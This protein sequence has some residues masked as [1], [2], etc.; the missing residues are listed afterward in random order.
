MLILMIVKRARCSHFRIKRFISAVLLAGV[1][2]MACAEPWVDTSNLALRTEIQYLADK[3]LIKAPVTTFPLMWE[4]IAEDLA[5][6]DASQLDAPT[7]NAYFNVIN[8]LTFAK[9]N[10]TSI[11][12]NVSNDD[13]RIVSFGEDFRDKNSLTFSYSAMGERW[14]LKV[15][16][17][18]VLDPN[19]GDNFRLDESYIAG[20]IGNWVISAG[21]QDRWLAPGWDSNLSMTNNARP[22]PGIGLTRKNS[23]PFRLIFTDD[24]QIPWTLTTFMTHMGDERTIPNALLWGFRLNFKPHKRLELGVTRL[25]QWAGDGRPSGLGTFW[26]LLLGRDH[27]G[28][29]VDCDAENDEEPGNQQLGVD[30]RLALPIVGHNIGIYGQFQAEDRSN[31]IGFLKKKRPQFGIDTTVNF[32]D[33]PVLLFLEYADTLQYCGDGEERGVGDCFYEHHLYHTGLR[34]K[35][36][37]IGNIYDND[38]K[39]YVFGMVSQMR[40]DASWQWSLRYVE[41]NTDNSDKFPG[42]PNGNTLTEIAEDMLMLSGKYQRV[43]GRWKF[44]LGG[45][46]SRSEFIDQKNSNNFAAFADI[47]FLL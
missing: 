44:T 47:E 9:R 7:S 27:C 45:N 22:M 21:L 24:Y 37:N 46:A 38:A 6:V 43:F 34:Y 20:F 40:N 23:K 29:N 17:S 26:D 11:K 2:A 36:R 32:S 28:V 4:A 35:G 33:T 10:I 39:S 5:G 31:G 30:F 15:S 25:A 13:N 1:T 18:Y 41:L 14:A 42:Q 8:Q 3:G 16:P 19:D 12:L